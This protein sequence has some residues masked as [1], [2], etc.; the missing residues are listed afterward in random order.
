MLLDGSALQS[1][2]VLDPLRDGKSLEAASGTEDGTFF[3]LGCKCSF[4]SALKLLK[5][6]LSARAFDCEPPSGH[7][8][9]LKPC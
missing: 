6:V 7:L 3:C 2:Q 4:D 1:L 8:T 5:E 9:E